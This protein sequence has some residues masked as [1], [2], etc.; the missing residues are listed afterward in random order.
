VTK[1]STTARRMALTALASAALA[2]IPGAAQAREP[3]PAHA[4]S[5]LG[6]PVSTRDVPW[7]VGLTQFG[8]RLKKDPSLGKYGYSPGC[9]GAVIGPRRVLTA[10]HCVDDN[11]LKNVVVSVGVDDFAKGPGRSVPIARVW[12]FDK[13]KT[14]RTGHDLAIVETKADLGV[15]PIPF[16]TTRPRVGEAVSS[17]GYGADSQTHNGDDSHPLLRR[18]DTVVLEE[19]ISGDANG[20]CTKDPRGGGLRSGDSG[21]PLVVVRDGAPQLVGDAS[22]TDT[23]TATINVF[24]DATTLQDFIKSPPDSALFPVLKQPLPQITGN[25]RPG[26]KVTCLATFAPKAT[27]ISYAWGLGHPRRG[28]PVYFR[29]PA[30]GRRI[31]G[32]APTKA[33]SHT[34]SITIPRNAGGK[35][36]KCL[37]FAAV[38]PYHRI[39]V[40]SRSLRIPRSG[41]STSARSEGAHASVYLGRPAALSDAPWIATITQVDEHGKAAKTIRGHSLRCTAAVIGPSLVLTATHCITGFDPSIEGVRVGTDNVLANPG[42]VIPVARIWSPRVRAK[43]LPNPDASDVALLETTKPLGVPAIALATERPKAGEAVTAFGFGEDGAVEDPDGVV[44]PFLRRWDATVLPDCPLVVS[45]RAMICV[46]S[47]DNAG[48]RPGDSGGPLVVVRDGVPQLVGDVVSGADM[49]DLHA[50]AFA[51]VAAQRSFIASRPHRSL[52]SGSV[53]PIRIAGDVRAGGNVT[54]DVRFTPKPISVDYRWYVGG[55]L[56]TSNS[57]VYFDRHGTRRHHRTDLDGIAS[58]KRSFTL[59]R[60]AI[61]KRIECTASAFEGPYFYN[62]QTAVIPKLRR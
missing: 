27:K 22:A 14:F 4:A 30:T 59:P 46:G 44:R 25:L 2:A 42:R 1:R 55:T 10:G 57:S 43:A 31:A 28:P 61:G 18:M 21:G 49:G 34:Q 32:Y 6:T 13:D 8:V 37:V 24:T 17:Y 48:T 9:S 62:E 39:D 7:V 47:G 38:G 56:S 5:Y 41:A 33:F 26:G 36:I 12:V 16:A 51:D 54:C 60:T 3:V 23:A 53:K 11:D 50:S 15:T 40:T 20:I 52:A 29:D 58:S 35:P 45:D 19:C